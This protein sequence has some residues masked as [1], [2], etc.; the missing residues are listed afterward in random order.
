MERAIAALLDGLRTSFDG[1]RKF[2][3]L[4]IGHAVRIGA[5]LFGKPYAS[6]VVAATEAA[7]ND[8]HRAA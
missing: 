3:L 8:E 2:F 6:A 4:Q 7:I 5:K 1:T